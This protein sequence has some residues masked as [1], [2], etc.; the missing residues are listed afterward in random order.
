MNKYLHSTALQTDQPCTKLITREMLPSF[1][2]NPLH[3]PHSYPWGLRAPF[4]TSVLAM[5]VRWGTIIP[6]RIGS[7]TRCYATVWL[8]R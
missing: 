2:T 7:R 6:W 8:L 3:Y 4:S 1:P 5:H